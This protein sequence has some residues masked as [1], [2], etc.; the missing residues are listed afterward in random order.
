MG[1]GSSK[2]VV[3]WRKLERSPTEWEEQRLAGRK[4]K[5]IPGRKEIIISFVT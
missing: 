3:E 1:V 5:D 4:G 2:V